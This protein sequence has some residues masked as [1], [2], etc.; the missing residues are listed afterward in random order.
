MTDLYK[1]EVHFCHIFLK[2][3][4]T[5]V[6]PGFLDKGFKFTKGGLIC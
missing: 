6:D 5:G 2:Q 3:Y 4:K 1:M